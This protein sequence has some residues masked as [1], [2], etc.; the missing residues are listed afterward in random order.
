[1][2]QSDLSIRI[3]HLALVA[4]VA[5]CALP[6]YLGYWAVVRGPELKAHPLNKRAEARMETIKPGRIMSR[7]GE[8]ILGRQRGE[9]GKWE[10]SYPSP[11]TFCHLTGYGPQSPLQASLRS[12]LLGTD[13]YADLMGTLVG[14]GRTGND[15]ELT[16]DADA[17]RVARRHL[18]GAKGAVVALEP[19][20]GEVL[21][22][23]S[24]PTYDPSEVTQTEE[25]WDLFTTNPHS[26]EL[27]RALQGLYPPGSIFKLITAAAALERGVAAVDT[28]YTCRGQIGIDGFELR[29]WKQGGHGDLRMEEAVAQS[30]N[31]YFGQLGE[32]L[33]AKDLAEYARET[34][35]FERPRLALAKKAMAASRVRAGEDTG[36]AGAASLAIGQGEL[37]ITPFAAA[38]MACAIANGGALMKPQLVKAVLSPKGDT[39]EHLRPTKQGQ[40]LR[41]ST[42][43]LLAG[44]MEMAVESGTGQGA[45]LTPVRVAG[46]TGSAENPEGAAHAWFVGFAPVESPRVA[47]AVIVEHGGSGGAAAAPVARD[48]MAEL[49]R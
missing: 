24:A 27:N 9:D 36:P 15:V 49:L 23:A 31:V 16:V 11:H 32:A 35:L 40:A 37:L 29:C 21:V 25:A 3:R 46:K 42:A 28:Q 30:C 41:S 34:G 47:V 19:T 17:Q 8:E 44:M 45:R 26:P 22:L 1:V 5:F 2:R 7:D 13:Q 6:F 4:L 10:A 38:Q 20:T 39:L 18:E 14:M 33:G 43:A 12:A 48:V